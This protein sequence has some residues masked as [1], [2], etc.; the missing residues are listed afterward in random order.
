MQVRVLSGSRFK[1]SNILSMVY[2]ELLMT[3]SADYAS[4]NYK[5]RAYLEL[6]DDCV[7]V[8]DGRAEL[9]EIGFLLFIIVYQQSFFSGLQVGFFVGAF[10]TSSAGV[11]VTASVGMLEPAVRAT[12]SR[13]CGPTGC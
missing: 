8:A 13:P 12:A 10:V 11:S 6:P 4:E 3:D 2:L 7:S 1:N 5:H 9:T